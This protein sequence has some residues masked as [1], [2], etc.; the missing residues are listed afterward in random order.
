MH[1]VVN[2]VQQNLSENKPA[3]DGIN[4]ET[5]LTELVENYGW[6]RLSEKITINCFTD[7]PSIK[8]SL[9]FLRKTEWARTKVEYLY[10]W[11]AKTGWDPRDNQK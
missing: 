5:M 1:K 2:K 9:K 3:L 8:S 11:R 10:T 6:Q 4:L 7:N